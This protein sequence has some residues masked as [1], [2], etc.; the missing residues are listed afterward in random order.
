[1]FRKG[2]GHCIYWLMFS[3]CQNPGLWFLVLHPHNWATWQMG[4][5]LQLT[6]VTS[7]SNHHNG[8]ELFDK[9]CSMVFRWNTHPNQKYWDTLLF[10]SAI[11]AH[12]VLIVQLIAHWIVFFSRNI[13]FPFSVCW[14]IILPIPFEDDTMVYIQT[15]KEPK[16]KQKNELI[17]MFSTVTEDKIKM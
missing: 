6:T 2:T 13:H 14:K 11:W 9:Y 17:S 8:R 5:A 1:M 4:K 3:A 7:H 16:T 12:C 10:A 15:R